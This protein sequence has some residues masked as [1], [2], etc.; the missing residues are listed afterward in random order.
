MVDLTTLRH[1]RH[2]ARGIVVRDDRLLLMERW[3]PGMYYFSIPGGG[4]EAGETDE[5]TVIRELLEETT[6]HVKVERQVLEMRD[7]AYQHRI[8]LCRYVS[9]EPHL[10]PHAPEASHPPEKNRFKPG[11]VPISR[12]P[13]LP[14]TYRQPLQRPLIDGLRNGFDREV[15]IVD[16]L[17]S[18]YTK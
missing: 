17:S 12:L 14:F 16:A 18:R 5:E 4:I 9:G 1:A 11:W 7:G 2:T 8:Y 3:R 13:E 10:P 15:V 6:I